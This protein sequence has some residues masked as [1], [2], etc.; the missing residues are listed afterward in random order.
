MT[1][2][3]P[4]SLTY[5]YVADG[6]T[7]VFPYPV[8]FL[9]PDELLVIQE[10]PDGALTEL[11]Y[12][13]DYTVT[14]AGSPSGGSI[15]T[16]FVPEDGRII[17]SRR[18][19]AKQLVDLHDNARNPAEAVEQQLDR[20]VMTDQDLAA[21]IGDVEDKTAAIDDAVRLTGDY[22]DAALAARDEAVTAATD[23]GVS[24]VVASGAMTTL[25]DPQF[26]T[27][28]TAEAYVPPVG[29]FPDYIR[30]A[31]YA[32]AGD[33]GGATYKKV[34]AEP[35]H[36]G[37]L[38]LNDGSSDQW[39]EIDN[40]NY[41]AAALGALPD[42]GNDMTLAVQAAIDLIEDGST[43]TFRPGVYKLSKN[44]ALANY[45]GDDQPC[46]EV[47]GKK[48]FKIVATGAVFQVGTHGQGAFEFQLCEDGEVDGLHCE[49]P[50]QFPPLDGTT[51]RG[52]KG[53]VDAGYHTSGFGGYYK[54]NSYD[55]SAR[56]QGGFGGAFPQWGGGTA[57]TW[58]MWNGGFIGNVG[59]G[60][61]VH[62][63]CKGLTFR[64][65]R[66]HHFNYAGIHVGFRGD[67]SPSEL[68]FPVSTGIIFD[69]CDGSDNYSVG[70]GGGDCDGYEVR[71]GQ[72][73]RVGHP[74]ANP[75]T[76]AVCDPG[77]GFG[78]VAAAV[79]ML[80][81]SNGYIHGLHAYD[82]KRKGIDFHAGIGNRLIANTVLRA[83]H[84]GIYVDATGEASPHRTSIVAFNVLKGNGFGNAPS[85]SQ[86][87]VGGEPGV[88]ATNLLVVANAIDDSFAS[89]ILC[90]Y[91]SGVNILGNVIGPKA[92]LT[93]AGGNEALITV[94]GPSDGSAKDVNVKDNII[95]DD[96]HA[97]Q[98]IT[99]SQVQTGGV[100][101]NTVTL[102][103][104]NVTTAI[105]AGNAA[106]ENV[107]FHNN[108]VTLGEVGRAYNL[109][110]AGGRCY[111]N[112]STGGSL[113]SVLYPVE[114][115]MSGI[116]DRIKFDITFNGTASPTLSNVIGS[117]YVVSAASSANGVIV[118]LAGPATTNAIGSASFT[119][120][121]ASG[122]STSGGNVGYIYKRSLST[123]SLEI[124]MKGSVSGSHIQASDVVSGTL[125]IT[126]E[127]G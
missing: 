6:I 47:R 15:T 16:L 82:C 97:A 113:E 49:G 2:P 51:G 91:A 103:G 121:G 88:A 50:G 14:G 27:K 31:G 85:Q 46:V 119:F 96:G 20:M 43:L 18:T 41:S 63:G 48:N 5:A 70:I 66:A 33:G 84:E 69:D 94:V 110:Y 114:K 67:H 42:T 19:T 117:N 72:V 32:E 22:K 21:R 30:T 62:N 3:V 83:G 64:K 53:V 40:H 108:R 68:G 89:A 55:T 56:T 115:K 90:R 11:G 116:A 126:V 87:Y 36:A 39:Y 37:K 52:E 102:L 101:G 118:T 57:A 107:S 34:G 127:F 59:F 45:P 17:I 8:R 109:H 65:A 111:A 76:D 123:K 23:A 99:W 9:E 7:T 125:Q 112:D 81:I 77:Y 4:G 38:K 35:S 78:G 44:T 92:G 28:T 1:V 122:L 124:G 80:P 58:G 54:N 106:C 86:I 71:G 73:H 95:F 93:A 79:G 120:G 75:L 104:P 98:G 74:D 26:A 100:S 12:N 29:A 105:F 10:A 61:L 13:V 60:I 25:L 24:A